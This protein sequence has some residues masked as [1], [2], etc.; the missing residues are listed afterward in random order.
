LLIQMRRDD[1]VDAVARLTEAGRN[2]YTSAFRSHTGRWE[3][4]PGTGDL[5]ET[6]DL[7]V[8]L[9]APHLDPNR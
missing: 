9:L 7:V 1:T 8:S 4:L 2:T 3:P 6:A 5:A